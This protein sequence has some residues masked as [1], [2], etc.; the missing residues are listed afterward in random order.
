MKLKKFFNNVASTIIVV[1]VVVCHRPMHC[2]IISTRLEYEFDWTAQI[3]FWPNDFDS[4]TSDSW[5][6]ATAAA[7]AA[8]AQ[9]VSYSVINFLACHIKWHNDFLI[10]CQIA[11]A[12]A[13]KSV[14]RVCFRYYGWWPFWHLDWPD[15][16]IRHTH[17]HAQADINK[18]LT[19]GSEQLALC[20]PNCQP[21]RYEWKR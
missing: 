2:T 13:I 3:A 6:R 15:C 4:L 18:H 7:A 14:I 10:I 19:N 12:P 9:L 20:A 1:V 8:A 11:C 17:T 16:Q 5:P 21:Q